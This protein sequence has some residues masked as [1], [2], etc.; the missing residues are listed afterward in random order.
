MVQGDRETGRQ[1][2][3]RRSWHLNP[4][5]ATSRT[6]SGHSDLYMVTWS[7]KTGKNWSLFDCTVNSPWVLCPQVPVGTVKA[8]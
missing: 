2:W 5:T 4:G 3:I 1:S 6:L 7:W 8:S